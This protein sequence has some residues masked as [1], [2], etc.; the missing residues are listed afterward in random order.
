MA[1][2]AFSQFALDLVIWV[3]AYH[4]PHKS[5]GKLVA[6]HHRLNM[7]QQAI[8]PY[9]HFMCSDIESHL[10]DRAYAIDTFTAL[11]A[12]YPESHWYWLIGVDA[13][14]SLPHWYQS[15]NLVSQCCWLIAPRLGTGMPE[16]HCN[17]SP[18][19]LALCEQVA[20]TFAAKGIH[21]E[22]HLLSMPLL[23]ISSSLIRH[24]SCD[25]HP[26]RHLVPE[27]VRAYILEHGLYQEPVGS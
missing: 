20:Q 25:R 15:Q 1:K 14:E 2:T 21:L 17:P 18:S 26:I 9:P 19:S 10:P 27:A 4:P 12:R 16:A 11:Q 7:V 6:F 24:Y 3:P 23:E 13:F 8:E 5:S 22:W